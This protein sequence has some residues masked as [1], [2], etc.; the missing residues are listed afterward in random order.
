M[1]IC[2]AKES[3]V[4]PAWGRLQYLS[5]AQS[6]LQKQCCRTITMCDADIAASGAA[7]QQAFDMPRAMLIADQEA[8][9]AGNGSRLIQD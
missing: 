5:E 7:M 6:A 1:Q 2:S 4:L 9:A 3:K 8:G